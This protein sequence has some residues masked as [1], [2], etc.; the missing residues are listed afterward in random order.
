MLRT[1]S[2]AR[3]LS[4]RSAK[5]LGGTPAQD[6]KNG[7]KRK[8]AHDDEEPEPKRTRVIVSNSVPLLRGADAPTT[9][10]VHGAGGSGQLGLGP[11][12]MEDVGRPRLNTTFQRGI[13]TVACGGMHSLLID[14]EGKLWSWGSNDDLA[15][16]RPTEAIEGKDPDELEA[17]PSLVEG[18]DDNFIAVG[19]DAGDC[20]SVAIGSEGQLRVW[21]T[22]RSEDGK[23][24]FDGKQKRTQTPQSYTALSRHRICQVSCGGSHI[25]A[26]TTEGTVF[27]WGMGERGEIGRPA[28]NWTTALQ[29]EA[30]ALGRITAICAGSHQ[31]FAVDAEGVVYAWGLNHM[32][33][34][35]LG[36]DT[37]FIG[38]PTPIE[39]LHPLYH[40]GAKVVSISCGE[41][42]TLFLFDNGE[43]WACGRCDEDAIGLAPDH[44]S[45]TAVLKQHAEE[46]PALKQR[47]AS[48]TGTSLDDPQIAN[49]KV[50]L[51]IRQPARIA[52]PPPP[53]STDPA[54]P[55]PAY[56]AGFSSTR[57]RYITT[58]PR[59]SLACAED[60]ALY[61]WGVG[62]SAQ[63]GLGANT[64]TAATP[65]RVRSKAL[66][67]YNAFE[68]AAGGQHVLVSASR[69]AEL[70][71]E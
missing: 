65:T 1:R 2:H 33:Q 30:L 13:Q 28:D 11:E 57:I 24:S 53:S 25:I 63:L 64:E 38:L 43:L 18:L 20:M 40:N 14:G 29:P 48:K 26:L 9:L 16:G 50:D 44:P 42:H 8:L 69:M 19:A 12:V 7:K 59:Y 49:L 55:L 32:H 62:T 68:V 66:N 3:P 6:L 5:Y 27:T 37:P 34:L 51:H 35:G 21:G 41:F 4:S 45:M 39:S 10:F 47:L 15:L 60:G 31:S 61:A 36:R 54:P 70:A 56:A 71:A 23:S 58:G 22:F 46:L 67:D 17:S 52:F